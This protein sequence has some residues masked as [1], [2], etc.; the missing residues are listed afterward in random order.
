MTTQCTRCRALNIDGG[1]NCSW[2]GPGDDQG[3]RR[4]S[5]HEAYQAPMAL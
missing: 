5:D 1:R 2:R 4:I 3:L